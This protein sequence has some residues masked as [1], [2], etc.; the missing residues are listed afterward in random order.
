MKTGIL[1]IVATPIGNLEDITFRAIRILKEADYVYAEDTRH[2]KTLLKKYDIDRKLFTYNSH[3]SE[4]THK[5]ILNS[6][7]KGESVAL[8]SDAG[9][10]GLSDPGSKLVAYVYEN[11]EDNSIVVSPIPGPS[12]A[13]SLISASGVFGNEYFFAGFLPQK[14]GRETALKDILNRDEPTV[15]YESCHRIIKLFNWI[16]TNSPNSICIIGRELTKQ[17]ETIIRG[18]PKEIL[19]YLSSSPKHTLGEFVVIVIPKK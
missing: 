7:I 14:K 18:T 19:N 9:T 12:A 6:L 16:E 11:M 3:A 13:V 8:V 17:F 15:L 2:T 4:K 5:E 10:P 1:Y